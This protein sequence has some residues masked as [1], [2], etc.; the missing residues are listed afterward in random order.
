MPNNPFK[1]LY[2]DSNSARTEKLIWQFNPPAYWDFSPP[3]HHF[4]RWLFVPERDVTNGLRRLAR[5]YFDPLNPSREPPFQTA[6]IEAKAEGERAA[7]FNTEGFLRRIH[8]LGL[9]SLYLNRGIIVFGEKEEIEQIGR[10][11]L[12]KFG[13]RYTIECSDDLEQFAAALEIVLTEYVQIHFPHWPEGAINRL[14]R[15]PR[16]PS[17]PSP[18]QEILYI[19]SNFET[20]QSVAA[21]FSSLEQLDFP[22]LDKRSKYTIF[23]RRSFESARDYLEQKRKYQPD[24]VLFKFTNANS[25]TAFDFLSFL[26]RLDQPATCLGLFAYGDIDKESRQQLQKYGVRFCCPSP[27]RLPRLEQ[28][29]LERE[30]LAW[31]YPNPGIE[32]RQDHKDPHRLRRLY[33]FYD[34]Q[35]KSYAIQLQPTFIAEGQ[36]FKATIQRL[37]EES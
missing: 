15:K 18:S 7:K 20:A 21:H 14:P 17:P 22:D 4:P 16:P 13:V 29:L 19:E 12:Q 33:H 1:L 37:K 35:G 23:H 25:T 6:L 8:C 32:V 3:S 5:H 31:V 10:D 27:L 24:V 9:E 28:T 36:S 2:V 26:Y 11:N 30:E 34:R